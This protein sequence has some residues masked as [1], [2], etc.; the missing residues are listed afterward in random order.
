M[1]AKKIFYKKDLK[2]ILLFLE[3]ESLA[4]LNEN[5]KG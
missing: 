2:D 3:E 4:T 5:Y 1:S